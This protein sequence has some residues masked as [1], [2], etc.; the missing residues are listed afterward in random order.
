MCTGL[1]F[2][3]KQAPGAYFLTFFSF[4]LLRDLNIFICFHCNRLVAGVFLVF[5]EQT[6]IQS[7]MTVK[8]LGTICRGVLNKT[9]KPCSALYWWLRTK[10]LQVLCVALNNY[11]HF[12][13]WAI[14]IL[15]EQIHTSVYSICEHLAFL[16]FHVLHWLI[17]FV[18]LLSFLCIYSSEILTISTMRK[19]VMIRIFINWQLW[20]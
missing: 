10:L 11:W 5:K 13:V 20:L 16:L 14:E 2:L 4:I 8:L 7:Y 1:Y 15:L 18:K 12:L 3:Q 17:Y 19:I 6:V 9:S